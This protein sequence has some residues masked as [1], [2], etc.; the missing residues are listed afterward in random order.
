MLLGVKPEG[1]ICWEDFLMGPSCH[2][3]ASV[4]TRLSRQ[5]RFD[6]EQALTFDH[7]QKI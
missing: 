3:L 6:L 7:I 2:D 1:N 4:Q 5:Y